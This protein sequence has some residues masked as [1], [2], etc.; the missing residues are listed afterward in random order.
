MV[1][2]SGYYD[3]LLQIVINSF[4]FGINNS[5]T[6][7]L[8]K[9]WSH[10]CSNSFAKCIIETYRQLY[11]QGNLDFYGWCLPFLCNYLFKGDEEIKKVALSVLEEACFDEI[12]INF[13][14]ETK[15]IQTLIKMQCI[16]LE[17]Q[18]FLAQNDPAGGQ[19]AEGSLEM[20]T[21]DLDI[22]IS[23]FLRSEKGFK[24]LKE[25]GW[26][27]HKLQ[28]WNE[29]GGLQYIMRLERNIYEG[30]NINTLNSLVQ[31][32]AMTVWIPIFE[33]SSDFGNEIQTLKKFPFSV[34]IKVET[35]AG[36][37]LAVEAL[38]TYIEIDNNVNNIHQQSVHIIGNVVKHHSVLSRLPLEPHFNISACLRLGSQFVN[39]QCKET[40]EPHWTKTDIG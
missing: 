16:Y 14:L 17:Q 13:L 1:D 10:K 38:Q 27:D 36:E 5:P 40:I 23:K 3:D 21:N 22:F 35:N 32:H 30:L 26:L 18:K 4:D 24:M 15:N 11:R 39:H 25:N 37:E 2:P 8:L 19:P 6:R 29:N 33:H 28:N 7:D 12:S 9:E 34:L 31:T 20:E